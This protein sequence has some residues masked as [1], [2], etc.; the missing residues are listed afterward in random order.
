MK[1]ISFDGRHAIPF[2]LLTTEEQRDLLSTVKTFKELPNGWFIAQ[3]ID[4]CVRL[5]RADVQRSNS[6]VTKPFSP[7]KLDASG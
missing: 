4:L 6:D 2:S 7:R 1:N 5:T 3:Y